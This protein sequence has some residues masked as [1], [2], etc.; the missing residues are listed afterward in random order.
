MVFT[1]SLALFVVAEFQIIQFVFQL[2]HLCKFY[3]QPF[4]RQIIL[5]R[6]LYYENA[7]LVKYLL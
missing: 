1:N 4:Q 5:E 2:I 6:F 7:F 3:F